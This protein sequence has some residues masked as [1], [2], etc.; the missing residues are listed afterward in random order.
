MRDTSSTGTGVG[1]VTRN[2]DVETLHCYVVPWQLR[3]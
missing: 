2:H 1:S 3:R